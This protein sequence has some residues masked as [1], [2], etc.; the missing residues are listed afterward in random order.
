MLLAGLPSILAQKSSF[1]A[2]FQN[3]VET[4]LTPFGAVAGLVGLVF[5]ALVVLRRDGAYIG[6]T[7]VVLCMTMMALEN[8]YFDNTLFTP[9]Q[10]F[11]DASKIVTVVTLVAMAVNMFV[12]PVQ[13][14]RRALSFTM[15]ALLAFETFYLARLFAKGEG[16][17][18]GLGWVAD[19]LILIT[20]G[21]GFASRLSPSQFRKRGM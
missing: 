11:R 21:V 13:G 16:V 10:Q 15:L 12:F 19:I 18:A 7:M 4:A 17:R 8:K 5:L 6:G 14:S 1:E 20:F 3:A 2:T 9:L